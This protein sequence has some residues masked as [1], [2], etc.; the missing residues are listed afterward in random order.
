MTYI[1]GFL[2][3]VPADRKDEFV[4]HARNSAKLIR[5]Y[6]ALRVVDCWSDDVPH[7]K[8]TD[9]YMAVKAKEGEIVAFGWVEWVS[10]EAR[11]A[12]WAAMMKDPR[13]MGPE[14]VSPPYDG[15]RMVYGGFSM[16][17]ENGVKL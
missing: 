15:A 4:A 2:A 3:A 13:M 1:D 14:A 7:G 12:A 10:K 17:Q 5:E 11:D 16:V 6:G 9:Y 8:Q